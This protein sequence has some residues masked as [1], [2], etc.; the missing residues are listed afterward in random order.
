[1]NAIRLS[2]RSL[3]ACELLLAIG[4]QQAV[5]SPRP[6]TG[7]STFQFVE[8]P[9]SASAG[10]AA[11]AV[12]LAREPVDVKV[13][14]EPVLP[15]ATPVYPRTALGRVRLPVTVGVRINVDAGGRVSHVGASL[16]AFSSGGEF[17]EEF[18]GAVE[19]AVAQWRFQ[20]AE[21][22]HMEPRTGGAGLGDYWQ[23]TRK[24]AVDDAFDVAFTFSSRGDVVTEGLR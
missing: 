22:R 7:A 6:V 10:S 9:V 13:K 17:G 1:M 19:A 18:R 3:V 21:W 12:T 8:R 4:C 15:L 23:I 20:P 16:V 2:L 24:Q 14:A 5:R 11:Q